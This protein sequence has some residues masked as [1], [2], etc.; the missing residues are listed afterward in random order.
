MV[1][2][3]PIRSAKAYRHGDCRPAGHRP[4][5]RRSVR[6][7]LQDNVVMPYQQFCVSQA[8]EEGLLVVVG[9]LAAAAVV[10]LVIREW[11]KWNQVIEVEEVPT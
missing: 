7:A 4:S 1:D 10:V 6:A 2:S 3:S 11:S 5:T 8:I 9:V